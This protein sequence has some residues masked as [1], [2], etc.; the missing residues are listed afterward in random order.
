MKKKYKENKEKQ[1]KKQ[2]T[3]QNEQEKWGEMK[4]K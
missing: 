2:E 1:T 4:N 3:G